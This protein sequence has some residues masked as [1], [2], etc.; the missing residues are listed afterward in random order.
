ML[1]NKKEIIKVPTELID[2]IAISLSK[3]NDVFDGV[4][5]ATIVAKDGKIEIKEAVSYDPLTEK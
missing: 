1:G 5:I 3:L 2:I 4:F